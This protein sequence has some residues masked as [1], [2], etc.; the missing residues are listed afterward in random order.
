MPVNKTSRRALSKYR[1]RPKRQLE[2]QQSQWPAI[3]NAIATLLLSVCLLAVTAAQ[4]LIELAR[5]SPRLDGAVTLRENATPWP[6]FSP[7]GY[8]VALKIDAREAQIVS[9]E[10]EIEYNTMVSEGNKERNAT[11]VTECT[12]RITNYFDAPN[13]DNELLAKRIAYHVDRRLFEIGDTQ[14]SPKYRAWSPFLRRT[15][16]L[17]KWRDVF[18]GLHT[19]MISAIAPHDNLTDI[20]SIYDNNPKL[21]IKAFIASHPLSE[22][23][24]ITAEETLAEPCRVLSNKIGQFVVRAPSKHLAPFADVKW[25][26]PLRRGL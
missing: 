25:P 8:K 13:A 12:L 7:E 10:G 2:T 5:S 26:S 9:I 6:G 4:Y 21:E 1:A 16:V 22:L 18:G 15:N 11:I 20:S 3:A 14:I 19:S 23:G 24:I 17:I